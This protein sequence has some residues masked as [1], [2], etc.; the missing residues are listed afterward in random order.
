MQVTPTRVVC[1]APE[2]ELS[3]RMIRHYCKYSD[4]FLRITFCEENGGRLCYAADVPRLA[5]YIQRWVPFF[6]EKSMFFERVPSW[7]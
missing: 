6:F 5:D 2:V 1:V 7:P 3:N 4:R